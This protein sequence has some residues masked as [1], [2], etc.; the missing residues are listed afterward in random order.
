MYF[1]YEVIGLIVIIFSPL[2]I[3]FRIITG[4][5]DPKRFFEKYCLYNNKFNNKTT[6]WLHG[7]SVGEILSII[8]IVKKL[9]KNKKIKRI[10]ITSST[11]SS[12]LILSR[13][14]FKKIIHKYFPIDTNYLS[15]KFI[16]IWKPK[17]AIFIESEIWPNMF[18]NL[19]KNKIPI[20]LLNA[21]I[22]KKSYIRWKKFPNFSK[23]IFNNISLAMPQNLQTFNYLKL[24][25]VKNIKLTGNLKHYGEHKYNKI[26]ISLKKKFKNNQIWCAASTHKD[27]EL[28]V[29]KVHKKIRLIK[30]N[31]L[32]IIIPRHTNRS[33]NIINEL[34]EIGLKTITHSS[35]KKISSETDIY[36][37]DTYGESSSFYE[38][39][40]VTFLGGSLI[41][42][43]G[44]N[45]LEPARK[46]NYILH[47]PNVDNFKEVYSILSKLKISSKINNVLDMKKMIIKK[48]N[49]KQSKIINQKLFLIGKKIFKKNLKEINKYI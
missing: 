27:E 14:K 24:L 23:I 19:N 10:L 49:F 20:I 29:G 30:K 13:Y 15:N 47:G 44:Q 31:L 34:N 1:I 33:E 6:I 28:F 9:E 32:T 12:S 38:L 41:S 25:G 21:R 7:A 18:K 48:I 16:K 4:K 5:E 43:G 11:T 8:P 36:L 46:K 39:S 22:T 42:R 2:I 37:V 17:L 45:P 40:N 3:L 26:N 35:G